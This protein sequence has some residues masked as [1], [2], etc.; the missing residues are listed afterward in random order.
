MGSSTF[1]IGLSG[2]LASQQGLA[3]TG[4][5]IANVN[6]PGFSRQRVTF[7]ARTPQFIGYGFVGKGTDV[8]SITRLANDFLVAQLRNS[9]SNEARAVKLEELV[10]RIDAQ[11]GTGLVTSGMQ[12]FFDSLGDANDDPQLMATRQVLLENARSMVSRFAEQE[13]ELNGIARS[14]NDQVRGTVAGI[15]ALTSAIARINIDISRGA[16]LASGEPPNDLLDR[17][18]QLLTELSELVGV[19][20]QDRGDG[21]VNVLLGDGQLVVTGGTA[22]TLAATGN[23]L[24]ASRVE[25]AYDVGGTLSQITDTL[26]GGQLGALLEFRDQ[27]L[28]PTRSAIG[29]LATSIAITV[30]EQHRQGMDLDGVLGADLFS[31]PTPVVNAAATNGGT[32]S[33]AFDTANVGNLAASDYR[34]THDGANYT[35]TRLADMST[36]TLAGTGPFAVDGLTISVTAPPA[37]G[38]AWLIQPTKFVPRTLQLATSDPRAL[39]LAAPVKTATAAANIGDATISRASILDATDPNLLATTT[40]VFNDPPTTYQVNGAGPAIA[41]SSGGD[42]DVNGW[43]VQITGTVRAGDTFTVSSNAGG[44]GDNGN[45]LRLSEMQFEPLMEG[46][47]ASY[48]EAYGMLVGAV[49]STAQQARISRE[50]LSALSENAQAARD[51]LS[52]VNLDEE[53]ANLLRFQQAYQAAARVISAADEAFKALIDATRS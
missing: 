9:M 2:L 31:V 29:R 52:G 16:G 22:T 26:N 14:V 37:A 44:I 40:L 8:Q 35:L 10:G 5:N 33:V 25:V 1:E 51:A 28:E 3:T 39:A 50:A 32:V 34:L 48:Q 18:D 12:N 4:H 41:W 30:N 11:L 6:T 27:T 7:E 19:Q 38:D 20:T 24:D 15:N 36:Q 45:G 21:M 17:R 53:A 13:S 42:I 23:P 43:R 49:G 47:A 46:G